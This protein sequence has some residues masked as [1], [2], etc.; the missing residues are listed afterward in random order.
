MF[1]HIVDNLIF[2]SVR[3]G[4]LQVDAVDETAQLVRLQFV[5][6]LRK[7]LMSGRRLIG[8]RIHDGAFGV[9]RDDFHFFGASDFGMTFAE[10]DV[11]EEKRPDVVAEAIRVE[12]LRVEGHSGPR[13]RRKRVVHGLVK[14]HEDFGG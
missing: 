5:H 4:L 1:S 12:L 10:F 13:P 7:H 6:L 8:R 9:A 14:V 11:L 3:F 2:K